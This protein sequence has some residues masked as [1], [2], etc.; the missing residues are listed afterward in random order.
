MVPA[1]VVEWSSNGTVAPPSRGEKAWKSA[2]EI[3]PEALR[4]L[5]TNSSTYLA[6]A[7]G[8]VNQWGWTSWANVPL[9]TVVKLASL[10]SVVETRTWKSLVPGGLFSPR[11]TSLPITCGALP[12]SCTL[13][14]G[15]PPAAG[16]QAELTLLSMALL[17]VPEP[18]EA[19]AMLA[20]SSSC[21]TFM[22][23]LTEKAACT[24]LGPLV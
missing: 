11:S 2:T 15:L 17:A 6:C 4:L 16:C 24:G 1:L 19:E 20:P 8:K 12:M 7:A 23:L 10:V 9:K 21:A 3:E 13:S 18:L 14:D 5:T 22:P